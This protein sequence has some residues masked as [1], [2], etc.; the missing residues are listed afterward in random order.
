MSIEQNQK[1]QQVVPYNSQAE[2]KAGLDELKSTIHAANEV[3]SRQIKGELEDHLDQLHHKRITDEEVK[4]IEKDN[5][6]KAAKEES[7]KIIEKMQEDMDKLKAAI[8]RGDM[9]AGATSG[10]SEGITVFKE[11]HRQLGNFFRK[12]KANPHFLA[13]LPNIEKTNNKMAKILADKYVQDKDSSNANI[14]LNS[15]L[16]KDFEYNGDGMMTFSPHDLKTFG[17]VGSQPDGG[18]WALVERIQQTIGRNF[19]TS[20][21]RQ[22][23]TLLSTANESIEMIIDDN[24]SEFGGWVAEV[25]NR[26]ESDTAQIGKK[27][28]TAHELFAQ[29]KVTQ[30][31][32]D[33]ASIDVV[34]WVLFK[35]DDILTRR[36]N[37]AFVQ[38][39]D[40]NKPE[41]FMNLG[42]WTTS[43]TVDS[44]GVYERD[45][46][47]HILDGTA[48]T[49]QGLFTLQ[50]AQLEDDRQ[51]SRFGMNSLTW[52]KIRLL[53][54]NENRSLLQFD[55]VKT[56][57]SR[58]LLGDPIIFLEDLDDAT[59]G[60]RPIVYGDFRKSYAIVDRI[61]MRTQ[62]D[63]V[64]QKGF[65]K[66]YT[67]KRVGGGVTSFQALKVL[68]LA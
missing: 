21:L 54:D 55:I 62:R 43:T 11:H 58:I 23:V 22:V 47:D 59:T 18:Y 19:L 37:T 28:I 30:K 24:E 1:Q 68:E 32:I 36:E 52:N 67:T 12:G 13:N 16:A 5:L 6:Y 49:K 65:V 42:K 46:L 50:T 34:G 29:P 63:D 27:V 31:F 45:K 3:A 39:N 57:T 64:T 66:F 26:D 8:N 10:D 48:I 15:F 9:G 20:P 4:L 53:D 41:G 61:G 56:D 35:T 51:N 60:L 40:S 7:D 2:V 17:Q 44:R 33:D 38:G 25:D 14:Q